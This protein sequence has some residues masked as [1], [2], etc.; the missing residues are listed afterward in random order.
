MHPSITEINVIL[1][2]TTV[3]GDE[4]SL[5]LTLHRD[6]ETFT[7]QYAH[8]PSSVFDPNVVEAHN[9]IMRELKALHP[10][11]TFSAL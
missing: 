2:A 6:G 10:E 8:L 3:S 9:R 11:N 4:L 7:S 5:N 1:E